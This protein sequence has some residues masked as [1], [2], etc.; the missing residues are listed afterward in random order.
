MA[1]A[2]GKGGCMRNT[3]PC[4]L[5]LKKTILVG[6]I[7]SCVQLFLQSAFQGSTGPRGSLTMPR[8]PLWGCRWARFI[9]LAPGYSE[10]SAF[11]FR[12][13]FQAI[14][15]PVVQSQYREGKPNIYP[16]HGLSHPPGWREPKAYVL[17][18]LKTL[19]FSCSVL[20]DSL[21]VNGLQHARPPCPSWSLGV[22]RSSYPLN[23]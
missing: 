8:R 19:F 15:S 9:C 3:V 11:L 4:C 22:C 12:K 21:R 16:S 6:L 17:N 20:S 2:P 10:E 7:A 13:Q 5:W 18:L 23:Q 1:R 14:L